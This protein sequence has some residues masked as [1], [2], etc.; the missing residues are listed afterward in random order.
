MVAEKLKSEKL[1]ESNILLV[2]NNPI[3]LSS[4]LNTVKGLP[5]R[6]INTRLLLT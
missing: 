3:E 5:N 6:L 1:H 2:G 4:I